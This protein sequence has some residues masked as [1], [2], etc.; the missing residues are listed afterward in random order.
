MSVQFV[1]RTAAAVLWLFSASAKGSVADTAGEEVAPERNLLYN[2]FNV[3][4]MSL[5]KRLDFFMFIDQ[6][7]HFHAMK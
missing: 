1:V 3:F 5:N 4:K 7:F 6:M 2:L